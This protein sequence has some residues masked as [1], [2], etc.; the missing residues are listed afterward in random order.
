LID[1]GRIIL[2]EW[3]DDDLDAFAA[4]NADPAV[5]E[6]MPKRLT[7]RE[8]DETAMRIRK[9]LED[10]GWG[11]WALEAPGAARF[12]GFV[13]LQPVPF[14]THFTPRVEVGWRLARAQWGR[15][16]ATEGARAAIAYAFEKLG[17]TEIVAM[18]V[19]SNIRSQRVMQR[20]GMTRDAADDFDHP[21]LAEGHPL[22]RHVLYR[23]RS[24]P[25]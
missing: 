20:L 17:E 1:T 13:G 2:R 24:S 18:T 7:P 12:C 25:A 23:M 22:R 11:L 14:E 8:S 9:A 3:R 4:L 5:M 10:R 21:R 15:G 6:H 19:P 16:Y